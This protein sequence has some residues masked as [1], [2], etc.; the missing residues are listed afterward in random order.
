MKIRILAAFFVALLWCAGAR[1]QDFVQ[2]YALVQA[3][4]AGPGAGTSFANTGITSF[5][6][7][8]SPATTVSTCSVQVD[9]SAD[10][11]TWGNGDLI[12]S[13]N[14]AVAGSTTAQVLPAGSNYVRVNVTTLTGNGG[15]N[16]TLKGWGGAG[17]SSGGGVGPGT[18]TNVGCF[19]TTSNLGNCADPITDVGG[20]VTI[21]ADLI[22]GRGGGAASFGL[23]FGPVS[24]CQMPLAGYNMF[25]SVT[26]GFEQ[27]LDGADYIP[28]GSGTNS[29]SQV[30][31]VLDYGAVGDGYHIAADTAGIEA[32]FT[33]S[34]PTC[35]IVYFPGNHR[36]GF[37][38]IAA[39]YTVTNFCGT[40]QGDGYSSTITVNNDIHS[41]WSFI[42]PH[43]L[44][45]KDMHFQQTPAGF[46]NG[47]YPV[48]I[49]TG[50]NILIEHNY[51]NDGDTA[52]RIG[53]STHVRMEGN[54]CS[55]FHGN[56]LFGP[57]D[58]DI[59]MV[60]TACFNNGD[61]CEEFSRWHFETSPI[62]RWITSTG[63][64]STNDGTG[65]IVDSCTE[66]A[67]SDFSIY[68]PGGGGQGAIFI[69]QDQL[70][71]NDHY[72]NRVQVSNGYVY[73]AGY[74]NGNINNSN[75]TPCINIHTVDNIAEPF[76]VLLSN[77][78]LEHCAGSAI[79]VSDLFFDVNLMTSNIRIIDAGAGG[80]SVGDPKNIAFNFIGGKSLKASNTY[81]ENAYGSSFQAVSGGAN[82]YVELTNTTSVNPNQRG[83]GSFVNAIHNR[84]TSGTFL[85]NGVSIIDTWATT[86]RSGI[87]SA[88]TSGNQGISGNLALNCTA[89]CGTLTFASTTTASA[90][91]PAASTVTN[92]DCVKFSLASN[93]VT[94]T[95]AG[96][97][98]GG[99]SGLSGMTATQLAVAGTA[100]TV[101]S[102]VAKPTGTIVGTTDTQTLTNKTLTSPTLTTPALGTPASG[103]L[104][105]VTGLPL[106]TGVTGNLPVTNLNSGTSADNIHFWR[107]DGTWA[108]PA[109]G[110]TGCNPTGAA[111]VVQASNGAG[112]CQDTGETDDGTTLLTPRLFKT[113][114][115]GA[116]STVANLFNGTLF[117]GGSGTTTKPFMYIDP[118][119][120]TQPTTWSTAGTLRGDNAPAGFTGNFIDEHVNGAASVFAVNQAGSATSAG[121]MQAGAASNFVW[122]GRSI[123]KSPSDGIIEM[124]GS[125]ATFSRLQL[126]GTTSSFPA[127]GISGTAITA[128]LAD[129]TAG[130]T[131][132]AGNIAAMQSCGTTST[133]SATAVTTGA[134][135]VFGSAPLVT[136]TPSSVTITGI[137]PAF[138]SSTSYKCTASDQT[139]VPTVPF[140]MTYV[141]GSS[142]TITGGTAIT[143]TIGYI[144]A[145]N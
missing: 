105:N 60:N 23:P 3:K 110:G 21:P 7:F 130:G 17:N 120:N 122:N 59:H 28:F 129:G 69:S 16:V 92:N 58:N 80:T 64:T 35:G 20:K 134:R 107:G 137:S 142:F 98:C 11:V 65:I 81:I 136:G 39:T 82:T 19:S 70:T 103:V 93:V 10:G 45:I 24:G 38:S 125:V 106:S 143:D 145:G 8:W 101:T 5:A 86:S 96:T 131:L 22:V 14:C 104:T 138:T 127:F 43:D 75:S 89:A 124:I 41:M 115:A 79:F 77:L 52:W 133:C 135:I 108:I 46:N 132:L 128:T 40:I 68:T 48:G 126:G 85:L 2:S 62:C 32:A 144:C 27:S 114:G 37:D 116:A 87:V 50:T 61:T 88:S 71:T 29:S 12:N 72:P 13:Q 57:N 4:P 90:L 42:F 49:D 99:S 47:T 53:N 44:T 26:G 18:P 1:A 97:T 55:N 6:I 83:T 91:P 84:N 139:A 56:C 67:I 33:A 112:A 76:N 113:T 141:S 30:F 78:H 15:I 74:S 66:V 36:Y 54:S 109:G 118:G 102:S 117:T 9:S 73:G 51:S 121:N 34:A 111:G 119:T 31:N 140:S 63:M 100:T 95:D 25:C 123:M 94:L